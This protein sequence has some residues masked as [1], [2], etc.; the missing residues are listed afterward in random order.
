MRCPMLGLFLTAALTPLGGAQQWAALPTVAPFPGTLVL[1][2]ARDRPVLVRPE[3]AE[4]VGGTMVRR[5]VS[6]A[7][8]E[9]VAASYDPRLRRVVVFGGTRP[10]ASQH[11]H[12]TWEWDGYQWIE[13]FPATMPPARLY[14]TMTYDT[15]R[16]RTVLFGGQKVTGGPPDL[17]EW[18]GS[19]WTQRTYG[20]G[21]ATGYPGQV[22]FD[23]ARG[24]LV[25]FLGSTA[26]EY[27]GA[28]WTAAIPAAITPVARYFDAGIGAIVGFGGG[29]LYSWTGSAW[30]AQGPAPVL[31][32]TSAAAAD[33]A[34]PGAYLHVR[35]G[36]DRASLLRFDAGA[37][38]QVQWLSA[39]NPLEWYSPRLCHDAARDRVVLFGGREDWWAGPCHSPPCGT[40]GIGRLWEWDS[41]AAVF[42]PQPDPPSG[43]DLELVSGAPMV[44]HRTRARAVVYAGTDL[45]EWDGIAW[46][47]HTPPVAPPPRRYPAM[48]WDSS[49]DRLVLFGGVLAPAQ[50]SV[51]QGDTWEHDGTTWVQRLPAA[52]P[53]AQSGH[54]MAF[55]EARGRCVL[56][57]AAAQTWEWDGAAWT[58]RTPANRPPERTGA[59]MVWDGE[60]QAVVMTGGLGAGGA[61]W[62]TWAWDGADW[63]RLVDDASRPPNG[64]QTGLTFEASRHRLLR[65]QL[66]GMQVLGTPATQTRYGTGC[67]TRIGIAALGEPALGRPDFAL[68]LSLLPANQPAL[69]ALATRAAAVP[70][71]A[72]C[73]L[74]VDGSAAAIGIG[75]S[76]GGEFR[77]PLAIPAQLSLL[78][79]RVFAQGGVLDPG[80]PLG[81]SL[82]GGLV[83]TIGH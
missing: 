40:I 11:Q 62:D 55:D 3:V 22:V 6:P 4:W 49:R 48:A 80:A 16:Q 35:Y 81:F 25:F 73:E 69:V 51:L 44:Y 31:P 12:G 5:P 72:G 26:W 23:S 67:G 24:R 1:D 30:V 38:L 78:G 53:A 10:T 33:P 83:L 13:R 65:F 42:V 50:G 34:L 46:S 59:A 14:A 7:P 74:L 61:R 29:T 32:A 68:E 39:S 64:W 57:G 47:Q 56:F 21:P 27:D 36:S 71:G 54:V 82:T 8:A 41:A 15:V 63:S 37:P 28:G 19:D 79:L 18:D 60:R 70:L 17:W 66:F 77:Y 76:G 43:V 2:T 9:L 58:L 20:G 45:L 52:S 75:S